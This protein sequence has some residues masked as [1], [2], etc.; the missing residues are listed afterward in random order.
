M[1]ATASHT[2]AGG[3]RAILVGS[4]EGSWDLVTDNYGLED[5]V[6]ASLDVGAVEMTPTLAP[7]L[8]PTPTPSQTST[9]LDLLPPEV[10]AT[11]TPTLSVDV[12]PPELAATLTPTL[13]SV[14]R[15]EFG[16]PAPS[17]GPQEPSPGAESI[18]GYMAIGA[19]GIFLIAIVFSR[20][21]GF[22]MRKMERKKPKSSEGP[23]GPNLSTHRPSIFDQLASM[24]K[25]FTRQATGCLQDRHKSMCKN[26]YKAV[27][28]LLPAIDVV[29]DIMAVTEYWA[30]WHPRWAS[31][32]TVVFVLSCRF[33][34]VFAA[35]HPPP[36]AKVLPLLYMF[37]FRVALKHKLASEKQSELGAD[38]PPK[39]SKQEAEKAETFMASFLPTC[40]RSMLKV[41]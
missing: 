33:V 8:A 36:E 9:D 40:L 3:Q 12:L 16:T 5:F 20:V 1:T 18:I 22:M 6:M 13:L 39:L 29:S 35:L 27:T 24:W 23:P 41:R 7:T 4:T 11:P 26:L 14:G 30:D 34:V 21:L 32:L 15:S 31:G 2:V 28:A 10:A 37:P 25:S 17:P 19:V 38:A